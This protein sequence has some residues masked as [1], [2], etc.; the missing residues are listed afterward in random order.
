MS[1]TTLALILSILFYFLLRSRSSKITW[2]QTTGQKK[3]EQICLFQPNSEII[4][5]FFFLEIVSIYSLSVR[6]HT[7]KRKKKSIFTRSRKENRVV[8]NRSKKKRRTGVKSPRVGSQSLILLLDSLHFAL[9]SSFLK[10]KS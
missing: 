6:I 8:L 10:W 4:S 5:F 2:R 9:F 7:S 3:C 1:S